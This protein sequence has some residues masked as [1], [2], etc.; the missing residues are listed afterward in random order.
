MFRKTHLTP[1]ILIGLLVIHDS[2]IDLIDGKNHNRGIIIAEYP[3]NGSASGQNMCYL[4]AWFGS[5]TLRK[6][7]IVIDSDSAFRSFFA[8]Q[9]YAGPGKNSCRSFVPETIDF[10][11]FTLLGNYADGGCDVAF[12]RLVEPVA[13]HR[14]Y[15]YTVKVRESGWCKKL[16]FSMN[17]V[18]VPK[19]PPG[20]TVEFK[21]K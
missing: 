10:T 8:Y 11:K 21:V 18:L 3:A 16:V 15:V 19:L 1:L 2:C 20:Y 14:K 7:D 9:T 4:P 17:W 5:D 6:Q 13:K 12:T